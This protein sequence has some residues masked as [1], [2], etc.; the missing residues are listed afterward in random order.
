MARAKT[1]APTV[2]VPQNDAEAEQM[3]AQLG[4][5]QRDQA[6][7]KA[8]HSAVI[9]K[10]EEDHGTEVKE[11]GRVQAGLI[12]GISAWAAAHRDRLTNGGRTK[13][14]QL[15]TGTISWKFGTPSVA[16]RGLKQEDVI[17]RILA[18]K[19]AV[20]AEAQQY[21]RE[22]RHEAHEQAMAEFRAL[23]LFVRA[24]FTLDK[25]AMHANRPLAEGIE[26]VSFT[27]PGETF[28]IE[29]LA[30]QISEVA[31]S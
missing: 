13:T 15:P 11:F 7:A 31:P 29:P 9:A 3:I 19:D 21:K 10:L 16:H 4:A 24:K 1:K 28:G 18:R 23:G 27:A 17:G 26:G 22:R 2:R 12:E 14:V 25:E 5:S 8:R 20:Y 6:I 30:S